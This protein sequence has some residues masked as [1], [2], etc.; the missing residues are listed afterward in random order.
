[1]EVVSER[2]DEIPRTSQGKF[3]AVVCQIPRKELERRK[4]GA[5]SGMMRGMQ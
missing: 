1:V 5:A 2:L 3:K 4:E